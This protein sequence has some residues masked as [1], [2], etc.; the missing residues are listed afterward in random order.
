MAAVKEMLSEREV[1][2]SIL[3]DQRLFKILIVAIG[4]RKKTAFAC[5]G[6]WTLSRIPFP[7]YIYTPISASLYIPAHVSCPL[8]SPDMWPLSTL[9]TVFT[10][11]SLCEARTL[12]TTDLILTAESHVSMPV[13]NYT[14]SMK[15]SN[16]KFYSRSQLA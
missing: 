10:L 1:V 8:P 4:L 7:F 16:H 3:N 13:K 2:G 11:S 5:H 14:H 12:L 6:R 15:Q 9:A